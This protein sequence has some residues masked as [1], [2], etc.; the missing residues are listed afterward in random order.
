M[1]EAVARRGGAC[2]RLSG[3]ARGAWRRRACRLRIDRLGIA[4]HARAEVAKPTLR[5]PPSLSRAIGSRSQAPH[6][7]I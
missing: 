5:A 7:I 1:T 6:A 4:L 2:S 3:A